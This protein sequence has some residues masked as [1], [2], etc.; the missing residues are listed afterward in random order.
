MR[1]FGIVILFQLLIPTS[2][3]RIAGFWAHYEDT[4]IVTNDKRYYT[5]T[6]AIRYMC[7][8]SGEIICEKNSVGG[9]LKGSCDGSG[10]QMQLRMNFIDTLFVITTDA[11][12]PFTKVPINNIQPEPILQ[13]DHPIEAKPDRKTW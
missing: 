2:E 4:L 1:I 9:F 11:W 5:N 8:T 10:A 7:G 13:T 12:I 6:D 3:V